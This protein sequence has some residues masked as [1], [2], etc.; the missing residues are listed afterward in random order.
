MIRLAAALLALL[1]TAPLACMVSR[2]FTIEDLRFAPIVL[3]GEVI[4]YGNHNF[5]VVLDLR[6][7]EVLQGTAPATITVTWPDVMS[8]LAPATW[9]RPTDI[10]LGVTPPQNGAMYE[11]LFPLCGDAYFL[12]ETPES[13]AQVRASLGPAE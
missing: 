2:P 13:L 1:P 11:I 6:V 9:D 7:T 5:K 3:R 8:D 12:P 4:G 10:I